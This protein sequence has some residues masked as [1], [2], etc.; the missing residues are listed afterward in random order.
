MNS[1]ITTWLRTNPGNSTFTI[2]ESIHNKLLT[3]NHKQLLEEAGYTDFRTDWPHETDS[4][5]KYDW[6]LD[7]PQETDSSDSVSNASV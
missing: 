4:S 2:I 6:P 5:D 7:W 3:R 1:L